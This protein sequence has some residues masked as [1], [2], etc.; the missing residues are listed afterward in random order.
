[1]KTL[2]RLF[3]S[4]FFVSLLAWQVFGQQAMTAEQIVAEYLKRNGVESLRK[5]KSIKV[6]GIS[7]RAGQK[8]PFRTFTAQP[9]LTRKEVDMG[10]S[11]VLIQVYD[12]RRAWEISPYSETEGP[13][14]VNNDRLAVLSK[15]F[16][17]GKLAAIKEF[18]FRLTLKGESIYQQKPVWHL[19]LKSKDNLEYE[20]W[21]DQESYQLVKY[22]DWLMSSISGATFKTDIEPSDYRDFKNMKLPHL[23]VFSVDG[24]VIRRDVI[25][26]YETDVPVDV[27]Y[28]ANIPNKPKTFGFDLSRQSERR[29]LE[30]ILPKSSAPAK[31]LDQADGSKMKAV[32]LTYKGVHKGLHPDWD[33]T[34]VISAT[35]DGEGAAAKWKIS[36]SLTSDI[37]NENLS[38]G[39]IIGGSDL[40]LIRD[41]GRFFEGACSY[42]LDKDAVQ[43]SVENPQN[44]EPLK[45]S[46]PW[47]KNLLTTG[48]LDFYIAGLPLEKNYFGNFSL[49][50]GTKARPFQL[51]VSGNN[52]IKTQAGTFPVYVVELLPLDGKKELHSVY[53]VMRQAP[54]L[55]VRKKYVVVP[56]NNDL[57][58]K[59]MGNEDLISIKW[60]N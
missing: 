25:S 47:N 49:L 22:T 13:S 45:V 31:N 2:M 23:L 41:Y 29:L 24:Q 16:L 7:E 40:R 5:L 42:T 56:E 30:T 59:S 20:F 43:I 6:Q 15:D 19:T 8:L 12:G 39:T 46:V 17:A 10:G 3:S 36:S 54:H 21:I 28:P 26:G 27:A 18:D 52:E 48:M 34:A 32:S 44:K 51:N 4:F 53:Y 55:A 58:R 9:N 33:Y 50:Y 1:M 38:E 11:S 60:T 14:W 35:K 57:A 37:Y